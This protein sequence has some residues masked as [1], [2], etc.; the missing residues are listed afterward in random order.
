MSYGGAASSRGFI[1]AMAPSIALTASFPA[2]FSIIPPLMIW[3][4]YSCRKLQSAI[5]KQ[6]HRN[7][8]LLGQIQLSTTDAAFL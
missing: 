8:I 5:Q 6:A 7:R 4:R 1:K 3:S 2:G